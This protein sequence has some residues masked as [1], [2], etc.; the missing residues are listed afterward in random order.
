MLLSAAFEDFGM[1]RVEFRADARNKKS[2]NA[3]LGIGCVFEGTLRNNCSASSGRRDSVVLSIIKTDWE[4]AI[5]AALLKK[6]V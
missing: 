4:K 1:E 2:I 5:K 6:I 3:M